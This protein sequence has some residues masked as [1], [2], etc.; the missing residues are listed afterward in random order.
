VVAV[1]DHTPAADAGV[2]SGDV[3]VSSGSRSVA[4]IEELRAVFSA[5]GGGAVPL[6]LVRKGRA[7]Q[8]QVPR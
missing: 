5:R 6:T 7:L 8:V 2:L 4:S 3:I 1:L